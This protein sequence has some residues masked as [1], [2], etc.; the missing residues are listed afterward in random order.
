MQYNFITH[1]L[2]K[3]IFEAMKKTIILALV[4]GLVACQNPKSTNH[5]TEESTTVVESNDNIFFNS[6]KDGATLSSPFY[7]D[8]GVEGMIVEPKGEP[9]EGHGHHHLIINESFAPAG[10]VIVADDNHIH[11]GGGQTTDSVA[12][13]S[14][15][16]KL[17][18]QFGDG[19]HVSYGE[20]WSKTISVS[21]K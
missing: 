8:M 20:E 16:Y 6:L 19:M 11:Y 10:T 18:L 7:L 14:G 2:R 9:R 3:Y 15:D 17:T 21:V 12:L 1:T 5:T 13:P 4:G